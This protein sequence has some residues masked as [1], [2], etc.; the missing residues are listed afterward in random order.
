MNQLGIA[1]LQKESEVASGKS[2]SED[3]SVILTPCDPQRIMVKTAK[4]KF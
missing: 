4:E 3:N 1:E 2:S